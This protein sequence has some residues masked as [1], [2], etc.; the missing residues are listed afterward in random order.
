MTTAILEASTTGGTLT[1]TLASLATSTVGVGRASTSVDNSTTKYRTILVH[2]KVKLG[3][4]PTA[5]TAVYVHLIRDDGTH[6]DDGVAN[7]YTGTDGAFTVLNSALLG[8]LRSGA[9]PSTGDSLQGT[10][11]IHNPGDSWAIA[12]W[13]D[14]GVNLDST[15]GN[16]TKRWQGLNPEIQA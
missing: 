6:Y 14:T 2:L 11:V 16:H 3:T 5:N 13:H 4:S 1:I 10:F 7:S 8:V 9:S 15:E 12:L